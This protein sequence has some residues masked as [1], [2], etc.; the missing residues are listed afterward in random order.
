MS[1]YKYLV[2][3]MLSEFTSAKWEVFFPNI[4]CGVLMCFVPRIKKKVS[5]KV[6][7]SIN[8]LKI[9]YAIWACVGRVAVRG[10]GQAIHCHSLIFLVYNEAKIE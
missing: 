3:Q 6:I 8:N 2:M 1:S 4:N 10:V 7:P 9:S 5:F